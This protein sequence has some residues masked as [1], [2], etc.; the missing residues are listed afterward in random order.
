MA[1]IRHELVFRGSL[2]ALGPF[3]SQLIA[4]CL[5]TGHIV[6]VYFRATAVAG[7][8]DSWFFG[9]QVEG[10]DVLLTTNRPQITS[11]DLEVESPV[12]SIAVNFRDRLVPTVNEKGLGSIVGPV[13]CIIDVDDGVSTPLIGAPVGGGTAN[14]ILYVDGSAN[15]GQDPTRFA[16]EESAGNQGMVKIGNVATTAVDSGIDKSKSLLQ[17]VD[18][19]AYSGNL[20][21]SYFGLFASVIRSGNNS[22]F[23][24]SAVR[25]RARYS[26][27]SPDFPI[28]TGIEAFVDNTGASGGAHSLQG[29]EGNVSANENAN[30]IQGVAA[31]G[32]VAAGKTITEFAIGILGQMTA[33]AGSTVPLLAGVRAFA[34]LGGTITDGIGLF[35][36]ISRG[37]A[38]VTTNLY[39]I[40]IEVDGVTG[41]VTNSYGIF[42]PAEIDVG[43]TIKRAIKSLST[44]ISEFAGPIHVPD[45]AYD[46]TTWDGNFEVPTKNALRDKIEAI[47]LA[48]GY[49]DEQAQDA[50]GAM[51]DGTLEYVDAT[52]LL[53]VK[54]GGVTLAKLANMATASFLGRNT[55]GT[56]VPEVLSVTTVRTMLG[57][58]DAMTWKGVIDCSANPNF[59][60][61]DAGDVYKVS[62]AGKIGGASGD[63][64]AVGDTLYCIADSTAAGTKAAVGAFWD[65]LETNVDGPVTGPASAVSANI[66]SFNGTTGKI[67]QDSGKAL[68]AG[69]ILGTSDTQ[70]LTNKRITPRVSTTASSATPTPN[71]D[72]D[73]L[74][75]ITA[76]AAAAAF[77]A[78]SGTPDPGQ[79][80]M[81]RIK[82]NGT[83]R[84]LTW[85]AIYRAI[86]VTLPA[87]TVISKTLYIGMIY[88]SDDS[89]WDVLGV[90][91]QA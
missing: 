6:R 60:A 1:T 80:M 56:G 76:Q 17:V 44:A 32:N 51:I 31:F 71:A 86:G 68:P 54:D 90:N 83:A 55:A 43:G 2:S 16:Y 9:L 63:N 22:F 57:I 42:I 87:T 4:D 81:I 10:T 48:G 15:L 59:P 37:T 35:A 21:Y 50:I 33:G 13:T 27:S 53:R 14:S 72:T 74:Y 88:N 36:V 12:V 28:V 69:T 49:T 38:G 75:K 70:T 30:D 24:T 58:A 26:G 91:Q 29:L 5:A 89:K 79:P 73:D 84:A 7:F 3:N 25:G 61:A 46:A 19:A 8:T 47:V 45:D 82:D 41:T 39:G 40:K 77:A 52:P 23:Q 78:P 64:V 18:D 11:G 62:V 34:G 66:A 65:I 20:G 85:D 67:I